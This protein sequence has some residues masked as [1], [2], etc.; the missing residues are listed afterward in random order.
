MHACEVRVVKEGGGQNMKCS[1]CW[2]RAIWVMR[3]IRIIITVIRYII[4]LR[5]LV[6][7][8]ISVIIK[9]S[10]VIRMVCAEIVAYPRMIRFSL[11]NPV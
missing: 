8:I 5:V 6:R 4:R 10:Q 3:V 11:N 2:V 1:D 7:V 9:V